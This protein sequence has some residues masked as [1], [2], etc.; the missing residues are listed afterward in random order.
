MEGVEVDALV[1]RLAQPR[2]REDV[3]HRER[4]HT[5]LAQRADGQ[6]RLSVGAC[7]DERGRAA[8]PFDGGVGGRRDPCDRRTEQQRLT[9]LRTSKGPGVSH[10]HTQ[11]LR[12]L[13][14]SIVGEQERAAFNDPALD[15]FG[16]LG[17]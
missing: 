3:R 4:P 9:D 1:V 7:G 2:V 6:H 8:G 10:V 12:Q 16:L 5:T 13:R 14:A 11:P 17:R 15:H